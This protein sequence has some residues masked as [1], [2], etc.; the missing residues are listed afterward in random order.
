MVIPTDTIREAATEYLTA[1]RV[2]VTGVS[3]NPKVNVSN[4]AYPRL[5]QR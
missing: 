4:V 2:A 3:G 1:K 5:R